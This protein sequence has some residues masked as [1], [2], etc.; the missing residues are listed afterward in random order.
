MKCPLI[1]VKMITVCLRMD[2][3]FIWQNLVIKQLSPGCYTELDI[4]LYFL[5]Y[6]T[7]RHV[8]RK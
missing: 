1:E 2:L 3:R 6:S 4:Y 5:P 7:R 8:E